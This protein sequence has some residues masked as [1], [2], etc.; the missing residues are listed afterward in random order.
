VLGTDPANPASS[1]AIA[2]VTGASRGIG[3]AVAERLAMDGASVVCISRN[4]DAAEAIATD[5]RKRYPQG[6]FG[7]Y[8]C[9][10][11]KFADVA[12]VVESIVKEF[13]RID[14]LVNNAGITRDNL[15]LR[16]SEE[17]WDEVIATNLKGLFNASKA[18]ARGMLKERRGRIIN[19]TSVVGL[20]GNAGQANYAA[21]KGGV[22]AFTF[23]LARELASRGITVNAVAPGFIETDMTAGLP[24]AAR[25]TFQD[26][27]PLGRF[28]KPEEVAEVVAFLSRPSTGYI[29]GE[30]IRVDGGLAMG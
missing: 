13:G 1:P 21:S 2:V 6:R 26:K 3:K 14:I 30:V 7:A 4:R 8:A 12:A 9:D 19:V 16:M 27:I 25:K 11:S 28:G 17:E 23:T 29:T 15:I 18:V 24:E 20:I 10:V 5:L 22:N